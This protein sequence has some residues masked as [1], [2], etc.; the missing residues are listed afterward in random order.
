[1]FRIGTTQNDI[2]SDANSDTGELRFRLPIADGTESSILVLNSNG[3]ISAPGYGTGYL[4]T[5]SNGA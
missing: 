1:M 2:V 4:K 5:D 3:N